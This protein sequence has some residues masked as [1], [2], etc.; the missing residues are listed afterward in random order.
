[1]KQLENGKLKTRES[2]KEV[3]PPR[4]AERVAQIPDEWKVVQEAGA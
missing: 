2:G 4:L 3:S 1:V